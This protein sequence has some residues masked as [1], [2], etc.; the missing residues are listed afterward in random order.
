MKCDRVA[1]IQNGS[2]LAI[3]TPLKIKGGFTKKLFLVKATEKYRLIT[4]LRKYP[5]TTSAYAFGDSVHTTFEGDKPGEQIK[6]FL[7]SEGVENYSIEESGASIEDR[8]LEL[9]A[10]DNSTQHEGRRDVK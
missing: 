6:V 7:E 5:G 10:V 4:A 9:M 2:I 1:L 8:F 3:D